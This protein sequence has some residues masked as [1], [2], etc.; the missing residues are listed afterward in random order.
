MIVLRSPASALAE[1]SFDY[2]KTT[3]VLPSPGGEGRGE[4]GLNPKSV[5]R[6]SLR[7][8]SAI[9]NW[10]PSALSGL[11]SECSTSPSP[12]CSKLI[13]VN[14]GILKKIF[15]SP[16]HSRLWTAGCGLWDH[17]IH[18]LTSLPINPNFLSIGEPHPPP[19]RRWGKARALRV[20]R[21]SGDD[22]LT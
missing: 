20:R 17:P 10:N 19:F 8:A 12:A 3:V 1:P 21:E 4:G 22:P 2:L 6:V 16:A 11:R 14:H 9:F 7:A 18:H 13:K 15:L 5:G